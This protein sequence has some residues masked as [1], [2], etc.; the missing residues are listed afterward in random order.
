MIYI[1]WHQVV[2]GLAFWLHRNE[3]KLQR[4][5]KCNIKVNN[6]Y[7]DDSVDDY[8]NDNDDDDDTA[9]DDGVSG[10]GGDGD[11]INQ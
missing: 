1:F 7:N 11:D 4:T 10:G 3:D 2:Q 6:D 9:D 5:H 8:E